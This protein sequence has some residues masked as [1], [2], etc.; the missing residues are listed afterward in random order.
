MVQTI[1]EAL[2][3]GQG[4]DAGI[5]DGHRIEYVDTVE[6]YNKW[7]EVYDTDGNFLQALDTIEMND[8]LPRFLRLVQAQTNTKPSTTSDEQVLRLVD[9]GCG[10]GRNTLQLTKS[11]PNEAQIIGL[12][13]SPGMLEVAKETLQAKGGMDPVNG[14]T[15]VLGVYD[16]LSP[17]PESLPSP[18]R[19][20]AG[21]LGVIST[22]VLEHIP[23]GKFFEGAAQLVSPGGYLLVTN[24]HEEMGS[25]S[26]AGFVDV[27][28]GKKIRPTSYAHA[29]GDVVTAAE[30][31]GFE[32]V[33]LE[34][35]ERFRERRVDAEMVE[36][37]GGR[38]KKWVGV[39]VW[40]GI[41]FRMRL[42]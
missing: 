30:R 40:F 1:Q 39:M 15:V 8:L 35:G 11:A 29:T 20:G 16:L 24:M 9:L 10:T 17:Q 7:A 18:L 34:D 33:E 22:L 26:Q 31:A 2:A 32:V 23:L 28:S 12:D 25:I 41:C 42:G 36:R 37:L 4:E 13:A 5:S 14:R 21:A 6:A 3:R 38:A 27:A 19:G